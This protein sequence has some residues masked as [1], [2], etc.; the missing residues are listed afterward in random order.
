[1]AI[2]DQNQPI[3]DTRYKHNKQL[4]YKIFIMLITNKKAPKK[5]QNQKGNFKIENN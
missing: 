3:I 1:M 2:T 4:C 5:G